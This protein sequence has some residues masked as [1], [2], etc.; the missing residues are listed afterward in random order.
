MN[1]EIEYP[2]DYDNQN[3]LDEDDVFYHVGEST[4]TLGYLMNKT[5]DYRYNSK[6]NEA[7]SECGIDLL[8]NGCRTDELGGT[9]QKL[10][11]KYSSNVANSQVS[12]IRR[13]SLTDENIVA[14]FKHNHQIFIFKVSFVM[15]IDQKGNKKTLHK[16]EE[17]I[18][19]VEYLRHTRL[20]MIRCT[21]SDIIL[22]PLNLDRTIRLKD[23]VKRKVKIDV[24]ARPSYLEI[25][26]SQRLYPTWKDVVSNIGKVMVE[27][28]TNIFLEETNNSFQ[29]Y[30]VSPVKNALDR[31]MRTTIT[32][33]A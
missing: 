31:L 26:G 28:I 33:M 4:H 17:D 30:Y 5:D 7:N 8:N 14:I 6:V 12:T 25:I 27:S 11:E 20:F 24:V 32:K 16:F 3:L 23:T 2:P 19:S 15:R 21:K 13:T 9:P 1:S 22:L 10:A 29:A 18:I